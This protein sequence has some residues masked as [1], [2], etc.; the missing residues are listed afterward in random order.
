MIL[1]HR[2]RGEPLY[3]NPDLIEAIEATPDTVLTLV[4]GRRT[5]VA[6]GIDDVVDRILRFRAQVLVT[7]DEMRA[8]RVGEPGTATLRVLP[9][10]DD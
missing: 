9:G 2:L 6:D 10:G 7:A 8:S 5:V 3:L 4:D 1:V